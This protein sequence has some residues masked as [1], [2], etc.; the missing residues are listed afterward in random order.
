MALKAWNIRDLSLSLNAVPLDGGG[1]AEDELMS[2]EWAE[3]QFTTYV[4]SDGEVSRAS[5]NNGVATVTL[6]YAQTANANDRLTALHLAD[7][8][9]PNGAGAGVFQARDKQGRLVVLSN[10]AWVKGLPPLT[11]GKTIQVFEWKIELAD[12][13][14]TS[15][16]GGR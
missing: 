7:L 1:Y 16:I 2:L 4:G 10:R 15:F 14:L 8:A 3:D 12:A 9:L 13:R 5:T 6:K 11:L